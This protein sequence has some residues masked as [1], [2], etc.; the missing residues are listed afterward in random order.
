MILY[1]ANWG[2]YYYRSFVSENGVNISDHGFFPP[3]NLYPEIVSIIQAENIK[4]NSYVNVSWEKE[5]LDLSYSSLKTYT[6]DADF[7]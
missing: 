2:D 5:A 4:E 3:F 7:S 6:F 1:T